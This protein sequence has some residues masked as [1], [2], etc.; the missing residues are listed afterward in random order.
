MTNPDQ[1]DTDLDGQG[2]VCDLDDDDDGVLDEDDCAP[3]DAG[4][5]AAPGEV[6]GVLLERTVGDDVEL[7]WSAEPTATRYDLAGGLVLEL[8][9]DGSVVNSTCL[10]NDQAVTS[11]TDTRGNPQSGDGYY[12]VLRAEHTCSG[13]YGLRTGPDGI[14]VERED[15]AAACP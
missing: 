9:G 2:N 14:D 5:Y 1:I 11:W 7:V 3:L 6:T 4:F 13:T 10:A 12:Y 15:P 8:L